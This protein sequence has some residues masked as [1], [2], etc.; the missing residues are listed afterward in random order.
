MAAGDGG[1]HSNQTTNL[2]LKSLGRK[3]EGSKLVCAKHSKQHAGSNG[4][5]SANQAAESTWSQ[6]GF[7]LGKIYSFKSFLQHKPQARPGICTLAVG[8]C[9]LLTA[10]LILI[11]TSS[12]ISLVWFFIAFGSVVAVIGVLQIFMFFRRGSSSLIRHQDCSFKETFISL[13]LFS[14][15]SRRYDVENVC[16]EACTEDTK[17]DVT[18]TANDNCDAIKTTKGYEIF[19]RFR[20][21]LVLRTPTWINFKC[22]LE[23]PANIVLSFPD[24]HESLN[25]ENN[26]TLTRDSFTWKNQGIDFYFKKELQK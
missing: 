1:N 2:A 3:G 7:I 21:P 9:L 11:V 5:G 23:F 14:S 15:A 26:R 12:R 20:D 17:N 4:Q 24:K 10:L 8:I 22:E 16:T 19:K 25:V 13:P 18:E 6:G